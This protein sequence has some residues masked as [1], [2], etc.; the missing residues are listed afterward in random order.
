[1]QLQANIELQSDLPSVRESG[2]TGIGLFR[3]EFLFM[4]RRDL[5]VRVLISIRE[6]AYSLIGSRFKARIPN[7]YGNFLHLDFLDEDAAREAVLA[8][9]A[10]FNTRLAPDAP[11]FDI[12]PAHGSGPLGTV[13]QDV[14][15]LVVYLSVARLLVL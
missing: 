12:D 6:D 9:V 8:P 15:S 13:V 5:P 7:V 10:A 11:R 2:A 1:M 14:L 3:S 4:N